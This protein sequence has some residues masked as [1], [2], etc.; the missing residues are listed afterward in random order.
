MRMKSLGCGSVIL[1]AVFATELMLTAR[2]AG[3]DRLSNFAGSAAYTAN[4]LYAQWDGIDNGG[5][6]VASDAYGTWV[7]LVD[8]SESLTVS[9]GTPAWDGNAFSCSRTGKVCYSLNS[10]AW[11]APFAPVANWTFEV[12]VRPTA[13]CFLN[14]SGVMGSGR[15]SAL[16]NNYSL[17][18]FQYGS[19][20]IVCAEADSS[21]TRSR[22]TYAASNLQAGQDVHLVYS[23]DA[24]NVSLYVNGELASRTACWT[25]STPPPVSSVLYLGKAFDTTND[26]RYFDG[27]I[28]AARVYTRA[29]TAAEIE[30]NYGI[31]RFRFTDEGRAVDAILSATSA[32]IV[33]GT[34]F[35]TLVRAFPTPAGEI[36]VAFGA[37]DAGTDGLEAWTLAGGS[38]IALP[39]PLAAG[40]ESQR[41]SVAIPNGAKVCRFFSP[42]AG[43]SEAIVFDSL[44]G[45]S[46]DRLNNFAGSAAYT[47]NGLYAQWDGIDNGGR[48][49]TSDVPTTWVN[50]V[51]PTRN[52]TA[53]GGTPAW[54]GNA[55]SCS[56]AKSVC[57]SLNSSA[58]WAPFAPA[59]NWTFE[60][61][62][63]PTANFFQNYSGVIGNGRDSAP[64]NYSLQ[65]FQYV[66]GN[67]NCAEGG[68]SGTLSR[69]SYPAS[70]L[71]AGQDVH[72]VYSCD[73]E[74]VS[75]YVDGEL[76]GRTA[77]WTPTAP[78][79]VSSVLNLGR[80][81]DTADRYFDGRIYA[82]RV[83]TRA[84]N[85][86][87]IAGNNGIDRL[88]F[89]DEGREV[90]AVLSATN[91]ERT[92][93]GLL[94]VTLVRAF[95][96][97]AGEISVAFG[98]ADEGTE[99]LEDWTFF[100][101]SVIALEEPLAAGDAAQMVSVAIPNGAKVC[102]FFTP[103]AGWSEAISLGS[104]PV[105]APE[106]PVVSEV[107]PVESTPTSV[108]FRAVMSRIGAG[109]ASCDISGEYRHGIEEAGRV[110][111]TR[112]VPFV[113]CSGV[114]EAGERR[115]TV[116]G[117]QPGTSYEFR[118]YAK[119]DLAVS[120]RYPQGGGSLTASTESELELLSASSGVAEGLYAHWDA[121]ENAGRGI[122]QAQ[123]TV[124]TNLVD[125][126]RSLVY[127][128]G[129]ASWG[130]TSFTAT[131]NTTKY[132]KMIGGS[133]SVQGWWTGLFGG[134][135]EFTMEAFVKPT[136]SWITKSYPGIMGCHGS[137]VCGFCFG[138]SNSGTKQTSFLLMDSAATVHMPIKVS[139]DI[140]PVDRMVHLAYTSDGGTSKLYIDGT[141]VESVDYTK[142]GVPSS[143]ASDFFLGRAYNEQNRTFD[144]QICSARIY[145]RGLS[146]DEVAKNC[147]VDRR[148]YYEGRY[149]RP[150]GGAEPFGANYGLEVAGW[151]REG[152]GRI[153]GEVVRP[154]GWTDAVTVYAVVGRDYHGDNLV[155]WEAD[156][157]ERVLAVTLGEGVSS[158][159]F[160]FEHADPSAAY[161]RLVAPADPSCGRGFDVWG[162]TRRLGEK[163]GTG[164]LISVR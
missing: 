3:T 53:S 154:A 12:F 155:A 103:V 60:V 92:T 59:T 45:A 64:S 70:N 86:A 66:N 100:G 91:C 65:M 95:P 133:S 30:G 151:L 152:N 74:N 7:N 88:R 46:T 109:A 147:Q 107:G 102:R 146:A 139:T 23:C 79:T 73:A 158:G 57:Y 112:I 58:W 105:F 49:V 14:Y 43:W 97:P 111:K 138:Q 39:E 50:L 99:R 119:N 41:V 75:L 27:R 61:F 125:Q 36:S 10:A 40:G 11:W 124:W 89:T 85:E 116:G 13:S 48:G 129:T 143:C 93:D 19:G 98:A 44:P 31:D 157:G 110:V 26:N 115:F 76:V 47:T 121:I 2:A 104:L 38:V 6:G 18:M 131:W 37:E 16:S 114:R 4:G 25:T 142:P 63:R 72:L 140:M 135:F 145:R 29:L 113:A 162:A 106:S 78:Q 56:R 1:L 69:L 127:A 148:R 83:Y 153:S 123:G 55:F 160:S 159:K 15:A 128:A 32:K 118:F 34:L 22:L 20:N 21:G 24:E 62:V 84:L 134:G 156:G 87:E 82:A 35:A 54:D 108:T 164:L 81:F 8:P 5:R 144:G 141:L 150:E 117:L 101:G 149:V 130:E 136:T 68:Q 28:Y 137:M 71:Q 52:L 42:V 51:D 33:H 77:C 17:Q 9:G 161:I 94:S 132:F 67:V 126:S 122:H 120:I 80:A 90:E 96:T 163:R